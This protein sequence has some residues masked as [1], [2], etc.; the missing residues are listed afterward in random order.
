MTKALKGRHTAFVR[1][2]FIAPLQGCPSFLRFFPRALPWAFMFGPYRAEK[3]TYVQRAI[4]KAALMAF[5]AACGLIEPSASALAQGVPEHEVAQ[6]R[7][8]EQQ[9]AGPFRQLYKTE[10]HFMRIVCRPTKKQFE[11]IASDGD[12]A[13]KATIKKFAKNMNRPI[14][15]QQSNPRR[16]IANSLAELVR[17]TLSPEQAAR[18]EKELDERALAQKRVWALT[19][20]RMVDKI[21]VLTAN[22]RDKLTKILEKNWKDSW[23]QSQILMYGENYF[24]AMP[25]A[26]ILPILTDNQKTVWRGVPKGTINFWF[27]AG[28]LTIDIED[29]VWDEDRPKEKPARRDDKAT[30]K[31][32]RATKPVEKK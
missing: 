11:K 28:M 15:N 22:Q 10:L 23:N 5:A 2:R 32:K 27:N 6:A 19:L 8:M 3:A 18:Y 7:R 17:S 20:V 14:D 12:S 25:D 13:L 4:S 26:E 21:L 24:P 16:M 29:E 9:F 1:D 30:A 31:G